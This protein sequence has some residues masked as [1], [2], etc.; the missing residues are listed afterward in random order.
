MI[1]G[2]G[3]Y[4]ETFFCQWSKGVQSAHEA[5]GPMQDRPV[6]ISVDSTAADL[7]EL[8]PTPTS[9]GHRCS[10]PAMELCTG[11]CLSPIC[12]HREMSE[13]GPSGK[14]TRAGVGHIWLTQT[15][16]PMLVWM[17]T[18]RPIRIPTTKQL[19][20]NQNGES[21]LN[22]PRVTESSHMASI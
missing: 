22:Q 2:T 15:W 8:V 4:S 17:S 11:L 12:S 10:V 19:L 9:S 20:R 5:D 13:Q 1:Y 6:C 21:P 3:A 16:F 14:S 18:G 7:H